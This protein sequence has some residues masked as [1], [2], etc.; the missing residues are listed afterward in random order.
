LLA[1][2]DYGLA[3]IAVIEGNVLEAKRLGKA[4]LRVLESLQH[5]NA[6]EI[7]DWVESISSIEP[8]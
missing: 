4:S 2:A 1:L 3:K 8:S 6:K 7:G 5:R